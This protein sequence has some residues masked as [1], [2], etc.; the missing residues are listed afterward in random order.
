MQGRNKHIIK[1]V[2][3][4]MLVKENNK[5]MRE[6]MKDRRDWGETCGN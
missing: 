5:K 4:F 3:L 2:I 1:V 6:F